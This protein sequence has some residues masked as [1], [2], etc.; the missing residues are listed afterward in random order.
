MVTGTVGALKRGMVWCRTCGRSQ[1]VDS[2]DCL[3]HGWPKCCG[4]TMT[5]DHPATWPT[6]ARVTDRPTNIPDGEEA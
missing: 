2:A 5:I 3:Q 1:S 4:C 6:D